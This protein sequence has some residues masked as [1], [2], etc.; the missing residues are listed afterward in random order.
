MTSDKLMQAV[1]EILMGVVLAAGAVFGLLV[2]VP[3]VG[4]FLLEGFERGF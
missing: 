2:V 3:F 4:I 1:R